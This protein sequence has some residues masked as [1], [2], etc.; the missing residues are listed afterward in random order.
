MSTLTVRQLVLSTALLLSHF[1][2][3][4]RRMLNIE[5][6]ACTGL[7]LGNCDQLALPVKEE[8]LSGGTVELSA[9][10]VSAGVPN[11]DRRD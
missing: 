4:T 1:D 10:S 5:C 2:I 3:R 7:R 9:T 6:H 8:S 11:F